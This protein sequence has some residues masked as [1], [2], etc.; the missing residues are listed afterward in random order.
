MW[1]LISLTFGDGAKREDSALPLEPIGIPELVF[2]RFEHNIQKIRGK[3]DSEHVK[4][5]RCT[6]P[7]VPLSRHLIGEVI[8][9]HLIFKVIVIAV[10]LLLAIRAHLLWRVG[11]C[12]GVVFTVEPMSLAS[13]MTRLDVALLVWHRRVILLI[14]FE[15]EQV[16]VTVNHTVEQDWGHTGK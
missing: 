3:S 13:V 12:W 16:I 8:I 9:V 7:K 6:F 5:S 2:E 4:R 1:D 15:P 10:E 14:A 11:G